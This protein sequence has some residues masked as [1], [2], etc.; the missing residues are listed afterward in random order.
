VR[1]YTIKKLFIPFVCFLFFYVVFMNF[2]YYLRQT[3]LFSLIVY[4]IFL[5]PLTGIALYFIVL[6][7]KQ[8]IK[9]GT[10][11]FSSFW[12]YLDIIPPLLLLSFISIAL[13]G[14]FDR[15]EVV[16]PKDPTKIHYELQN[17][18]LE[19]TL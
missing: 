16:D 14:K 15:L 19:A 2:I 13:A 6:E 8:L 9:S 7:S 3:N 17:Q 10:A 4:Y 18:D 1:K 5:A 11:Y 12:N